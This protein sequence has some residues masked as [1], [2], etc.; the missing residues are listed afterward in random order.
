[1]PG[2][3][4]VRRFAWNWTLPWTWAR[5]KYVFMYLYVYGPIYSAYRYIN[6][7]CIQL[8]FISN[9]EVTNSMN[10]VNQ[11]RTQEYIGFKNNN[12]KGFNRYKHDWANAAQSWRKT[13]RDN[14]MCCSSRKTATVTQMA[15]HTSIPMLRVSHIYHDVSKF[16]ISACIIS[17]WIALFQSNISFLHCCLIFLPDY[18]IV[19]PWRVR[20]VEIEIEQLS[21]VSSK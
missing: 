2:S 4:S 5:C 18:V 19:N 10:I 20:W 6:T 21:V 7:Y 13:Q 14:I 17:W 1:M 3:L 12:S 15:L 11:N 9:T 16:S 8:T